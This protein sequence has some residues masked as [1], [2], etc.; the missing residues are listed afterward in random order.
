MD[1]IMR[2]VEVPFHSQ[3]N[4]GVLE[5]TYARG[6]FRW[7]DRSCAVACLTMVLGHFGITVSLE[8]VLQRGLLYGA[9]DPTRGWLHSGQVNVLQSYGLT[10][11]RRNWRLMHGREREYLAGR[12]ATVEAMREIELVK[13]QLIE[14]GRWRVQHLLAAGVPLI[15]SVYRPWG[16]ATSIGHQ[17]VLLS[18]DAGVVTFHD[19]ALET[20]AYSRRGEPDF[21]ANWKGT[22]IVARDG[23][24]TPGPSPPVQVEGTEH[25]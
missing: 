9:F 13:S 20:G 5:S 22:A 2:W 16:D 7:S 1:L 11:Y 23:E 25:P 6:T 4:I 10:A 3:R 18:S 14:E 21:F 17:V 24:F 8:E 19:P 15:M 12:T